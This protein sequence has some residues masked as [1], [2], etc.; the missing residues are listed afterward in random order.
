MI[1]TIEIYRAIRE[2]LESLFPN[3]IIQQ[4]DIKNIIRPSFYIQ[5]IGKNF[6]KQAQT[7]FEDRISFNIIYFAEKEELLELLEVE[8]TITRAFNAPL[9][10][11]DDKYIVKVEKDSIQS[12]LNEEDYYI[13]L[14]V[15]FVLSQ[16]MT[17]EETGEDMEDV[18]LTVENV[19]Q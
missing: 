4:K 14:T 11:P 12:N 3:I 1:S 2:Q 6:T 18:D 15:D 10:V 13:N 5:Y 16:T 7:I 8:E 17:E 9:I 19:A